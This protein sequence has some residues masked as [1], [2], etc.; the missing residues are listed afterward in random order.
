MN[1]QLPANGSYVAPATLVLKGHSRASG[2]ELEIGLQALEP[3][4][5]PGGQIPLF[6]EPGC[7]IIVPSRQSSSGG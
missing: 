6:E 7:R 5:L 4:S 2:L 1:S 3:S